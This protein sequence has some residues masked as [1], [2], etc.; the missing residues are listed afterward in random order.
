MPH[1]YQLFA[2]LLFLPVTAFAGNPLAA[3][4]ADFTDVDPTVFRKDDPRAKNLPRMMSA[5]A[6]RRMQEAN[7]RESRAFAEVRTKAGWERY[8]D[9]RIKA[10]RKSLGPFPEVPKDL[11]VRVTRQLDGDGFVIRCVVYE[12]RPGLWVS[13]N[14]YL[15]ATAPEKMPGVL[16]SHSHHT[17]KTHG[18]LQD[19]GM[20]WARSGVAVLVPD[21]LGH[22]ERAQ[23]GFRTE[24]DYDRPFRPG[25]QDYYF[26]YNSNLQ[27]SAAGESLT[28]WMAW[29]LMRGVD[30]LLRQTNIDR[31]RII[32]LGAVAGGGD[33]AGVTAA[34]D[35]RV[36]CVVPFNFG[37]WQPESGVTEDPD[38]DFAW[39]GDGYWE[40]TRGLRDGARDG[41]AHFAIVGSV[42]PRKVIYAHEFAWDG[43]TDPAWP[44]LRTIFG[45]HGAEDGLR[46]AHGSGSVRGSGPGNTHCTQVGAVHRRMI[47]PALR[48]WFGMP[49]PEEYSQRRP[50][51]D[52]LCWTDEARRE[53]KPQPLHAVVSRLAAQKRAAL[54]TAAPADEAGLRAWGRAT[55]AGFLGDV[56][57]AANPTVTEGRA[58]DV[59]GGT[60][61]RFA[62]GTDAGVTVP[63]FLVTPKGAKGRVPAVVMVANAGKQA[64]LRERGGEIAALLGAGVAVGLADVRGTGETRP[65]P[66][67]DR[68]SARTSVSQTNL[69]LG[70]PVVG[71]QLRDLRTVVRWLR[72]RDGIDGT[73]LAVWG[74]SFAK[75]NAPGSRL[76]VPLDLD[77]P[78]VSEPG[79]A[80]L[81]LLAGLFEDG[82][83]AYAGGGL[84]ADG[85]LFAGPYLYV[86][87]DAV[88]P[89][90]VQVTDS[91][92]PILSASH[93]AVLFRNP[94]DAQ[95]RPVGA[96]SPPAEAAGWVIEQLRGK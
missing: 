27:L 7:L 56:R 92:L 11:R 77:T 30:L 93:N 19:M 82:L 46:V 49:V 37:G 94:V 9:E 80:S 95:N 38:R 68:G 87:H 16:I 81:A 20:T 12:T 70:Q 55:W 71:S 47:Y 34:L 43:K 96:P 29:D 35:P 53:L 85:S 86:P 36:A 62:L 61:A 75:V 57:P 21:H 72:G 42:A 1:S 44:R 25:R 50:A 73:R 58:E 28:G 4:S 40:S 8:R 84:A 91:A 18:E 41:F 14:L 65:G 3:A 33:P 15:P 66:S 78:A 64:F 48:D 51:G 79:G 39:F 76:A 17:P 88:V 83:A 5:D 10:L 60:L 59:P 89:A 22:G 45:F 32:L 24:Q 69:I 23:H 2:T 31:D 52:L 74:D 13:A 6:H 63:V 67:A 54:R 26:R 90:P